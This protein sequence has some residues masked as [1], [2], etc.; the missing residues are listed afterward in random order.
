[1]NSS[2]RGAACAVLIDALGRFPMQRRDDT[3]GIVHPGKAGLFG[4]H[5][6][7]GESYL[8]CI[9]REIEEEIGFSVP[10]ERFTFLTS[11][12][13]PNADCH[14]AHAYDESF[15]ATVFERRR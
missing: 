15:V 14:G 12:V 13:E 11:V 9:M 4:G 10:A 3:P 7:G 5:R 2:Q 1:M 6:H 8:E